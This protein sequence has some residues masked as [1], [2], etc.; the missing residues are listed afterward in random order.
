MGAIPPSAIPS[1]KGIA[2]NGGVSRTGPLSE[3]LRTTKQESKVRK[4][5]VREI[6]EDAVEDLSTVPC[7]SGWQQT[8]LLCH[9][10]SRGATPAS[11]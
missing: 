4:E 8:C 1:R 10:A 7:N 11:G 5:W 6:Q 3:L 9:M 2:R